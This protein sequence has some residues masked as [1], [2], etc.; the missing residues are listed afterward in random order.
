M[1]FALDIR[2]FLEWSKG[3]T[4]LMRV[5]ILTT[6]ALALLVAA[7]GGN[8]DTPAPTGVPD[9]N[10]QQ[11]NPTPR[12][13]V[14]DGGTLTW[15]IISIPAN[16]NYY[17]LDGA[18]QEGQYVIDA[19]MPAIFRTDA[20][21]VPHWNPDYLASDPTLSVDPTQVV[22][23][24]INPTAAW[25]DGTPITWEDF[26]WQWKASSGSNP[27]YQIAAANGYEDI[28]SV[29]RGADDREV[30]VT[31]ARHF[32]E[33]QSL[34][35]PLYPASTNRNP[36]VFNSGWKNAPQVTAGP[37]KFDHIDQTA[38][39]I[40]LVRNEKWWGDRAKLD[41]IVFRA[42]DHVAQVDAL[43]NGEVDLMD[44]GPDANTYNRARQIEGVE[45]RSAGGP[46]FRHLTINGTSPNLQDVRV[47]RALAMA[48]D[49]E[50]IAR[51]LLGPLG[52]TPQSL[53]NHIFMSNVH[54][55][56]DNSGAVGTYDPDAA[57]RLLDEAGWTMSG[58]GRR[59]DGRA[60]TVGITIPTGVA[61]SRQEAE[62]IQNMLNQVGFT[63]RI[64]VVPTADFFDKYLSPG[65]FDTSVF[66]WIGTP[67]P[68]SSS[69]SV[70]ANPRKLED[71][72]WEIQQNFARTGS[73]EID[74]LFDEANAEL[75]REKAIAIANHIDALLW[76][77]VHS[78]AL[79]QRPDLWATR[80]D[81]ANI[82]AFGFSQ[83]RV[84]QDM[85]WVK[86]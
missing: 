52:M 17:Q 40:T 37:F 77:E 23:Y 51:A 2:R 32:S 57:R 21:G 42:I 84:Y 73:E 65:Q 79:Y 30:V 71:G 22:T 39:T 34:F 72:T 8:N 78:L 85:G 61:V 83:P 28:E 35:Y 38:K 36:D 19:L 18:L 64:D 53:G 74:A 66:S 58:N 48:I 44:I 20:S 9:A 5:Q 10:A 81:L 41:R 75:D 4:R 3:V 80:R 16:F 62:L 29:T 47:R 59:K 67:F 50:A 27:A 43:A 6:A 60:L 86:E 63:A 46:N 31:F 7:C 24:R 12:D 70:Y 45:I 1:T 15:A 11:I 82:G 49:R 33:W 26:Y 68:I 25:D 76:E 14:R 13:Q 69:K 54:G 55:Y 56:Q